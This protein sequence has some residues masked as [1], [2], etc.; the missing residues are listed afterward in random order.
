MVPLPF[1]SPP[2]LPGQ[3]PPAALQSVRGANFSYLLPTG[4]QRTEEGPFALVL[5]APDYRAG[6]IVFGQSGLLQPL[7]PD[8]FAYH[9]LTDIMR[10]APD[11]RLLD[12]QPCAPAPGFMYGIQLRCSYTMVTP[13]GPV[14]V[15]G[16]VFG[17]VAVGYGHCSGTLTLASAEVRQWPAYQ[18]WLPQVAQAAVNVGPNAYGSAT[19]AGVLA[20]ISQR[21][22]AAY[23][24]Y[25][26]YSQQTWQGVVD[27]R[28]ASV[29]WQQ[30]QIGPLLTGQQWHADPYGGEP[31]RRSTTPAV[32]W[33]SRDGR[34]LAS[35]DPAFDPRTPTDPDWR[36]VR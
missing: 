3:Q 22:H 4:W 26:Q 6:I 2:P 21:D 20:E 27:T 31:L 10:L 35:D 32:I 17:S 13:Q 18:P 5:H 8:Q 1:R 24:A 12:G 34:E 25:Q 33:R 16:V 7:S 11:I 30:G 15:C 29:D 36:R 14:P 19:T 9:A 28:N 23:T